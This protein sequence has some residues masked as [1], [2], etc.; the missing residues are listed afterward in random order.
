VV[1]HTIVLNENAPITGRA[2][3]V[4]ASVY[5]AADVVLR[6]L[7]P[8]TKNTEVTEALGKVAADYKCNPVG[9]VLSHQMTKFV[10][11]GKKV[12]INKPDVEQKVEEVEFEQGEVC[13]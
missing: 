9:G 10:I 12:I 7:K 4:I 2:A 6:L 8:G 5:T 1:A 11:D 13:A 3:D